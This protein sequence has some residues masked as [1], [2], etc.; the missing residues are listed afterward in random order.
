M[1]I[2]INWFREKLGQSPMKDD[3]YAKGM[4]DLFFSFTSDHIAE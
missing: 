3:D 4:L 2:L 1:R